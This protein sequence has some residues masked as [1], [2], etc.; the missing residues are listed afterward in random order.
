MHDDD[1]AHPEPVRG[2]GPID[3][4]RVHGDGHCWNSHFGDLNVGLHNPGAPYGHDRHDY[5]YHDG[6]DYS[7]HAYWIS[8]CNGH[9]DRDDG[10]SAHDGHDDHH[11]GWR[12][13]SV[14]QWLRQ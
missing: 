5:D 7:G 10:A 6:R 14:H 3:L 11:R 1:Q 4:Q 12:R 9:D 2:G 8:V 13:L